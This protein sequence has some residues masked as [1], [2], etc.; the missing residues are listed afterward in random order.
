MTQLTN[1][2]AF[3]DLG[4]QHRDRRKRRYECGKFGDFPAGV[5]VIKVECAKSR[6]GDES[7]AVGTLADCQFYPID[8]L[9]PHLLLSPA[10]ARAVGVNRRHVLVFDARIDCGA[11]QAFPRAF[12]TLALHLL[13]R[14]ST[15]I[16]RAPVLGSV[17]VAARGVG[18]LQIRRDFVTARTSVSDAIAQLFPEL[19]FALSFGHGWAGGIEILKIL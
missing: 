4:A 1:Q 17:L 18:K 16:A 7:H 5:Q 12:V 14:E 13:D 2:F 9:L 3:I 11:Y 19:C 15:E 10:N 8:E 6:W